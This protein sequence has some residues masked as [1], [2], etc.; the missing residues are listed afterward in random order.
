MYHF[1]SQ[2]IPSTHL[3]I[4]KTRCTYRVVGWKLWEPFASVDRSDEQSWPDIMRYNTEKMVE[5]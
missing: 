3:I 1:G 4:E 2:P 5:N